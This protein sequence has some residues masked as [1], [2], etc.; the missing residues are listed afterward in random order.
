MKKLILVLALVL[1]P[2]LAIAGPKARAAKASVQPLVDEMNVKYEKT[3]GCKLTVKLD[4]ATVKTTNDQ[5]QAKFIIENI[6]DSVERDSGCKTPEGKDDADGKAAIC[7]M[8]T[9]TIKV[10]DSTDFSLIK[11]GTEGVATINKTGGN[12]SFDMMV[13]KLDPDEE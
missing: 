5:N 7:K 4:E 2:A 8:K 13:N 12:P 10:G 9:L 3:C 6:R 1:I 11:D